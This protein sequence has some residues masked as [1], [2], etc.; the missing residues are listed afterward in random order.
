MPTMNSVSP[1]QA[2]QG[3]TL[4]ITI[5]GANFLGATAVSFGSGITVNSFTVTNSTEIVAN[6]TVGAN[7]TVG[8]RN[9]SVTTPAAVANLADVF[10]VV[11]PSPSIASVTPTSGGQ[12]AK[13]EVI[14]TGANFTGATDV[15]FGEGV[16]VESF[17]VDSATQITAHVN[18][19]AKAAPGKRDV[20]VITPDGSVTIEDVFEVQAKSGSGGVPV[21]VWLL[22]LV[23]IVVGGFL[24]LAFLLKRRKKKPAEVSTGS[25]S[26]S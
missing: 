2:A 16:T 23:I 14:I 3:Q 22:P 12:G 5:T 17:T 11:A 15:K 18:V 20:S 1:G 19:D 6:I 13:L 26:A 10:T 21:F 8:P 9:V 24:L 25:G 7:A 4:N